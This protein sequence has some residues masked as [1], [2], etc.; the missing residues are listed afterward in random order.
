MPPSAPDANRTSQATVNAESPVVSPTPGVTGAAETSAPAPPGTKGGFAAAASAAIAAAA[1]A[2][3]ASASSA[4]HPP[5]AAPIPPTT[6][7]HAP[8]SSSGTAADD[9]CSEEDVDEEYDPT[10]SQYVPGEKSQTTE[11]AEVRV[12][13]PPISSPT[14]AVGGPPAVSGQGAPQATG[15]MTMAG[16][17]SAALAP[18]AS[19]MPVGAAPRKVATTNA[20]AGMD[21]AAQVVGDGMN[22]GTPLQPGLLPSPGAVPSSGPQPL[23]GAAP[24]LTDVSTSHPPPSGSASSS[25]EATAQMDTIAPQA[26]AEAGVET[27]APKA[28]A[29]GPEQPPPSDSKSDPKAS[30]DAAAT[31]SDEDDDEEPQ[32]FVIPLPEPTLPSALKSRPP[33]TSLLPPTSA[34]RT[35]TQGP[36]KR[37]QWAAEVSKVALIENREEL[38]EL[39]D[40][41]PDAAEMP[42]ALLTPPPAPGGDN[43][44]AFEMAKKKERDS[45]QERMRAA[46]AALWTRLDRMAADI[47][48]QTPP[49]LVLIPAGCETYNAGTVESP[50]RDE[51]Q[52]QRK[53]S[54]VAEVFPDVRR[55]RSPPSPPL[56]SYTG[57]DDDA[58]VP[59]IP[60]DDVTAAPAEAATQPP[61]AAAAPLAGA[62]TAPAAAVAVPPGSS[63]V[64][65]P[66]AVS[67]PHELPHPRT[68]GEEYNPQGGS[69]TVPAVDSEDVRNGSGGTALPAGQAQP[70]GAAAVV[71]SGGGVGGAPAAGGGAADGANR[72]SSLLGG[73]DLGKLQQLLGA[74]NNLIT[75]QQRKP[76]PATPPFAPGTVAPPLQTPPTSQPPPQQQAAPAAA[77][78]GYVPAQEG[79]PTPPGPEPFV[80]PPPV[81]GAAPGPDGGAAKNP[82]AQLS[83]LL[84]LLTSQSTGA[85]GGGGPPVPQ[86]PPQQLHQP[87]QQGPPMR[88][89][90]GPQGP[91]GP[92]GGHMPPHQMG[93]GPAPPP[94]MPSMPPPG[95][96]LPGMQQPP[97]GMG[98]PGPGM[99]GPGMGGMPPPHGMGPGPGGSHGMRPPPP[100]MQPPGVGYPPGR[101]QPLPVVHFRHGQV[102]GGGRRDGPPPPGMPPGAYEGRPNDPLARKG[103]SGGSRRVNK[104]KNRVKCL[105]FNTPR[106]CRSGD[107]CE[108]I[109][110]PPGGGGDIRLR[111]ANQR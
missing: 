75:Q 59:V 48:Y 82:A 72:V 79:Q 81:N 89:N 68:S 21:E 67:S 94:G 41:G 86:Q 42:V 8:V 16:G 19:A 18:G 12:A 62:S 70:I 20:A 92:G 85:T 65:P 111:Y 109:H 13:T 107:A 14:E 99:G 74:T 25:E 66:A 106:G 37:V 33:V 95:M 73:L 58:E 101:Q 3:A 5:M 100:G 50:H 47:P 49:R 57:T 104:P 35:A 93:H 53:Q 22:S 45:E 78:M 24:T 76:E 9:H 87:L 96:V 39:W 51:V 27:N 84:Q 36:R 46:K 32:K 63:P 97:H 31:E 108:Y 83:A 61:A 43:M 30:T 64:A 17:E 80:A 2:A 15:G 40:T 60:L 91:W 4:N 71:G 105:F 1:A 34:S 102:G 6:S 88:H 103:G 55:F 28:D 29:L 52:R 77:P 69:A 110:E 23:R 10:A 90:G 44:S 7:L 11:G 26:S 98:G 54:P 56:H 38:A